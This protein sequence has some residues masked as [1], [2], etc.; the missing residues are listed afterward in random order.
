MREA[1]EKFT[2][3]R[4]DIFIANAGIMAVP[5]ALTKD[6]YEIQFGT[7]HIGNAALLFRLLPVMLKT[8]ALPSSDVRFISLTSQGYA[9]HPS[10]GIDFATLRT[11]QENMRLGS[12]GRY[13]QSKLA[14]ILL[15]K[16]VG[17]RYP[18]IL[19]VAV[20]PGVVKTDLVNNLTFW[21]RALV[22]VTNPRLMSPDQGSFNTLW[23][24]TGG[25]VR[26]LA[27]KGREEGGAA[28]YEPI[29][30]VTRGDG[31]CWDEKL[32]RELWEWT[33]GVVGVKV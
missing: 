22:F 32:A 27:K 17:R 7:N 19:S 31:M 12:W 20:H 26:E 1:A 25:E 16:E 8:A 18:Q 15:A 13:G 11:T 4:L 10:T 14:N 2:E 33:E 9:G 21:K 29:G 5:A 28:F 23:A 24:A 6:G 30:K 3:N